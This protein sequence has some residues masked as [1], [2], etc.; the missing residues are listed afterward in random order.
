MIYKTSKINN[1]YEYGYYIATANMVVKDSIPVFIKKETAGQI[2][3][4]S[5][6]CSVIPLGFCSE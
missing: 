2:Q 6:V 4:E 3:T 1:N 5:Q